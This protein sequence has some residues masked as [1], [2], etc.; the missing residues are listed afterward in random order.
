MFCILLYRTGN[1]GPGDQSRG[2]TEYLPIQHQ[3]PRQKFYRT[4]MASEH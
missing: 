4:K 1:V 2:E 3:Y